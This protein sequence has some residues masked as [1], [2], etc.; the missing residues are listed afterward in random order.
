M[1][2]AIDILT[3][4]WGG[5]A[6]H[7]WQTTLV[8]LPLFALGWAIRRG[9]GRT[10]NALWWLGAL[11]LLVPAALLRPAIEWSASAVARLLALPAPSAISFIPERTLAVL[12]PVIVASDG[13]DAG[14]LITSVAIA[15]TIVWAAGTVWLTARWLRRTR[16]RASRLAAA[17]LTRADRA[18]L[19]AALAGSSVPG[20]CVR[21]VGNRIVPSVTGIVRP[22]IVL[23][24]EAVRSLT[25]RE[26]RCVLLHEDAHRR[27]R[28]PLRD[29]VLR[30]IALLFPYY[31][32]TGPLLRRIRESTEVT[33]DEMAVS[34]GAAPRDYV[35]ALATL[36]RRE[37]SPAHT[38]AALGGTNRSFMNTRLRRLTE[39]GRYGPMRSQRFALV[40]A[41]VLVV[42]PFLLAGASEAPP[43]KAPAE[44][45]PESLVHM[46]QEGETLE[47]IA[48]DYNTTVEVLLTANGTQIITIHVGDPVV[49]PA[50]G[51]TPPDDPVPPPPPKS[52]P[53]KP[54]PATDAPEPTAEA[55][56]PPEPTGADPAPEGPVT[57]FPVP[58][59]MVDPTYPD[60]AKKAGTEGKVLVR[61]SV[62]PDGKVVVATIAEGDEDCPALGASAVE[63]IRQW[64]FEAGTEDGE[65]VEMEVMIPVEFKLD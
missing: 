24:I 44:A 32:L 56:D 2:G 18:S 6:V 57:V 26:L 19:D 25:M 43:P 16:G 1:G 50:P 28:D 8:L 37:L 31:P 65:P 52:A 51:D 45:A 58:I 42:A 35:A 62:G 17:E 64:I 36:L 5:V 11:K 54:E 48:E 20:N 61:V 47:S 60:E 34:R 39:P 10:Q 33:C 23:S 3:R 4:F 29:V 53:G 41:V 13:G 38:A 9:S 63:A 27:R 55:P 22:R 7:L 59:K 12:D 15:L 21:V 49:V 40:A 46:V 30:A 14:P